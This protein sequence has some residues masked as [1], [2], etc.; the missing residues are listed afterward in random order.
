MKKF[1]L[2]ECKYISTPMNQKV[3]LT[4]EDGADKIDE[5]YYRSLIG[6][7]MYLTTT[8]PNIIFAQKNKI[9]IFV[10]NQAAIAIANNPVCHG[11]TKH[12]NMKLYF[13][14]KMQQSGEVNLIYCKSKDQ[15]ADMFTKSL[16]IN[17][18][19]LLRQRIGVC[20]SKNKEEC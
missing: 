6:C 12:F 9:G 1:Q 5:G 10:D 20:S 2:E 16:P 4:K 7:L 19:E 13:L 11:K 3:K 14:R 8:R 18:F 17:K 15:L